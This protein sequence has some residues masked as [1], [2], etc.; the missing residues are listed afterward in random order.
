[1]KSVHVTGYPGAGKTTWT[2]KLKSS[3]PDYD[4]YDMDDFL[5]AIDYKKLN[6]SEIKEQVENQMKVVESKAPGKCI[7]L[8]IGGLIPKCMPD[9]Y[10]VLPE[11]HYIWLDVSSAVCAQRA[12]KRQIQWLKQQSEEDIVDMFWNNPMNKVEDYLLS[13][14]SPRRREKHWMN[15]KNMMITIGFQSVTEDEFIS[16]LKKKIEF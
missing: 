15:L 3:F 14:Y 5:F 8:G 13:Y 4:I 7:F 1:M 9:G 10:P 12:L 16:T 2:H 11:M 6:G